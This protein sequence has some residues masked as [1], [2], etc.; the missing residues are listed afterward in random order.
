[1]DTD[2]KESKGRPQD[3]ELDDESGS[4]AEFGIQLSKSVAQEKLKA[5][6]ERRGIVTYGNRS[7]TTTNRGG[8]D[9]KQKDQL[10]F[11]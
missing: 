2:P 1:V 3:Q 9:T 8:A 5:L 7:T 4:E 11:S 10:R 6:A